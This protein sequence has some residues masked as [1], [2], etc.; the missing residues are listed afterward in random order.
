MSLLSSDADLTTA[1]T[2]T[3][4]AE[5]NVWPPPAFTI[6]PPPI[7]PHF[8]TATAAACDKVVYKNQCMIPNEKEI[9]FQMLT[10]DDLLHLSSYLIVGCILLMVLFTLAACSLRCCT[11]SDSGQMIF[12]TYLFHPRASERPRKFGIQNT[13][14]IDLYQMQRKMHYY[15]SRIR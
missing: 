9:I 4:E 12:Q 1:A 11:R 8:A 2:A 13:D 7:P 3:A 10:N 14:Q 5:D 15:Y 6:P